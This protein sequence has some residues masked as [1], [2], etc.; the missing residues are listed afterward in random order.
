M[1]WRRGVVVVA[2]LETTLVVVVMNQSLELADIFW[3]PPI[4]L[5]YDSIGLEFA[6]HFYK[7]I[8]IS[9]LILL[10]KAAFSS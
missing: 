7:L 3:S 5:R 2:K 6:S 4:R 1:E 8:I 10:Y 9:R